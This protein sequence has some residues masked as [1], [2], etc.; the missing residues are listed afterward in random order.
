L[1]KQTNGS[2]RKYSSYY[3]GFEVSASMTLK[4]SSPHSKLLDLS[5]LVG[6]D[7]THIFGA[8]SFHFLLL[9]F[10]RSS[11]GGD[12]NKQE[13]LR[14]LGLSRTGKKAAL[15]ERLKKAVAQTKESFGGATSSSSSS[16]SS[17][18]RETG[19][20]G[21][22]L[23]DDDGSS[24]SSTT[25]RISAKLAAMEEDEVMEGSGGGG[26]GEG[27]Q[28][29]D[30]EQD[31]EEEQEGQKERSEVNTNSAAG[32]AHSGS[33]EGRHNRND[34]KN[35]V[36]A[37]VGARGGAGDGGTA[38]RRQGGGGRGTTSAGS[39]SAAAVVAAA[40]AAARETTPLEE[41]LVGLIKHLI[42]AQGKRYAPLDGE[43]T[44]WGFKS[45]SADL[46]VAAAGEAV[47][48]N[49]AST[50]TKAN[51]VRANIAS[52]AD[53]AATGH[54]L[55]V[56]GS[57]DIGRALKAAPLATF[58]NASALQS[59]KALYGSLAAFLRLFPQTFALV[60]LGV[61]KEFGIVLLSP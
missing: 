34:A 5:T 45:E 60:D 29:L 37:A 14:T 52:T 49:T 44:A 12:A 30:D 50:N 3:F 43:V 25:S 17:F 40:A 24:S 4:L 55:L 22:G 9:S 36:F 31:D 2:K 27:D 61:T 38:A 32:R 8:S 51:S 48:A 47:A 20:S 28:S 57:R 1:R 53:E 11:Y 16:F 54:L 41:E 42:T 23:Q 13:W 39:A 33:G 7:S 56:L 19:S 21:S 35:E 26:G 6:A 46:A 59:V 10:Y 18:A 58:G 15:V